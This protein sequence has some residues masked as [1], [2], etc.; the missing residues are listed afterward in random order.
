MFSRKNPGKINK[1]MVDYGEKS[2][3]KTKATDK[4]RKTMRKILTIVLKINLLKFI[5]L[6]LF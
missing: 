5:H 3:Q 6:R 4:N 2:K 1:Q